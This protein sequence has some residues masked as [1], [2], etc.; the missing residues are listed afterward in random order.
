M[1]EIQGAVRGDQTFS[2]ISSYGIYDRDIHQ[3]LFKKVPRAGALSWMRAVEGRMSKRKVHRHL[4]SFYEE[5]QFF[6][7]AAT[8]FSITTSGD[9]VLVKL[10]PG[11]HQESG[12]E[13]FPVV[14]Q[15]VVFEDLRKCQHLRS[16]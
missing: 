2:L 15:Q 16:L 1:S 9:D 4:Y 11:D 6:K 7:A 8:I 12:T 5:G 13:S 14:N 3:K 10:S